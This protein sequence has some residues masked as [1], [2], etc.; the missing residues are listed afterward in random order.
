MHLHV[1]AANAAL[2]PGQDGGTPD[3]AASS[4]LA[5]DWAREPN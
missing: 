1:L 3:Q 2:Q 5:A 4:L